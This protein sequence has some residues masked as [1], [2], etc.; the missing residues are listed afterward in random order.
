MTARRLSIFFLITAITPS[1]FF[2]TPVLAQERTTSEDIIAT[3][4][5]LKQTHADWCSTKADENSADCNT[6]TTYCNEEKWSEFVK[7]NVTFAGGTIPMQKKSGDDERYGG[8]T[9]EGAVWEGA[10]YF[11]GVPLL[12]DAGKSLF[13]SDGEL[14]PDEVYAY[15]RKD[16]RNRNQIKPLKLASC[17][18][19]CGNGDTNSACT[20]KE[21][22]TP[23]QVSVGSVFTRE[24]CI[25]ACEGRT[26]AEK[27]AGTLPL[28]EEIDAGSAE[29]R[30]EALARSAAGDVDATCFTQAECEQVSGIWESYVVCSD[31]K[32]RCYS[33]EPKVTLN[34]PIGGVSSIRGFN[35]YLALTYRYALSILAVTTTAMFIF[36]AFVYLLAS[37]GVSKI[38]KGKEIMTDAV[39][40]MILM[41]GGVMIFRTLNPATVTLNPIKVYMVNTQK[42][43]S[44]QYCSDLVGAHMLADAGEPPNLKTRSEIGESEEAYGVP[45]GDARCGH[46]FYIRDS[47]AGGSCLGNT[48]PNGEI[49]VTCASGKPEECMGQQSTRMVCDKQVFGGSINYGDE[50]APEAVYLI[51]VC[52]DAETSTLGPSHHI[53]VIETEAE[54][55]GRVVGSTK[56]EKDV[57][58]VASYSFDF[59][60]GDVQS[61]VTLCRSQGGFRGALL[62]VQYNDDKNFFSR[63]LAAPISDEE[64]NPG[65]DFAILSRN[66][67]HNRPFDAYAVGGMTNS[68]YEDLGS[69]LT[70]GFSKPSAPLRISANYWTAEELTAAAEG[71]NPLTCNFGLS[72]SNAPSD[73]ARFPGYCN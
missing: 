20:G 45:S 51:F 1:V 13:S 31:G 29:G 10:K 36:G 3:V 39:I 30:A 56:T 35:N 4:N 28:I 38:E 44:A 63:A 16:P 26:P 19:Q 67:C 42:Y 52:N 18:C 21:A 59:S 27:C 61:A 7:D 24:Q 25:R 11:S 46:E 66:N 22:G 9:V 6:S 54:T 53:R 5:Y 37:G 71:R 14:L 49:C 68:A 65:D 64:L 57:S 23:F 43:L 32:G 58:G 15:L 70:C 62:A 69:G 8:A 41:L 48:C 12:Y 17:F 50:R 40:G 72:E 34:V 55:V 47:V 60:S 73:A 33:P 2:G